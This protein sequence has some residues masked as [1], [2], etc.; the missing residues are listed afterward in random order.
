MVQCAVCGRE[1]EGVIQ[2]TKE[3]DLKMY[4]IC[5]GCLG[6]AFLLCHEAFRN[7]AKEDKAAKGILDCLDVSMREIEGVLVRAIEES[8]NDNNG[9]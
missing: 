2:I 1:T 3:A 5:I 6:S 7:F 9:N 4:N 8:E